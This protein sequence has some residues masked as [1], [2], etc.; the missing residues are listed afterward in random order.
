MHILSTIF[1]G[2][3]HILHTVIWLYTWII[4]VSALLSWVNPD[5]YNPIVRTLRSLT[6]P[7]LWRVRR[8]FP[9][10]YINGVDLSPVVVILALQFVDYVLV[11]I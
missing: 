6:E 10:T 5:P 1:N 4:I 2:L 7:V 8:I 9:F 11:N 3:V